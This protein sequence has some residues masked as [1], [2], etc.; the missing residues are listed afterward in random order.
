MTNWF[1]E[2]FAP[3]ESKGGSFFI[4]RKRRNRDRDRDRDREGFSVQRLARSQTEIISRVK[5]AYIITW[6]ENG[7]RQATGRALVMIISNLST[8]VL[9]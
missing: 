7:H 4:A 3:R 5:S 1:R 2:T 6:R 8:Y 9:K